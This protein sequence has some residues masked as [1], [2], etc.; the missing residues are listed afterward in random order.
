MRYTSFTRMRE[1]LYGLYPEEAKAA[2]L[3]A[4][5][6]RAV[7]QFPGHMNA[8]GF[9]PVVTCPGA[10]FE[11][12]GCATD[13]YGRNGRS[14][15]RA[16]KAKLAR[17]THVLF[18]LCAR[19]AVRKLTEEFL[20]LMDHAHCQYENRLARAYGLEARQLRRGSLFR[21]NWNGDLA[22]PVQADAIHRATA[23]RPHIQCWVY[24]RSFHLLKRLDPPP[25][26]LSVWLS[27]DPVNAAAVA[28]ALRQYPWARVAEL[29]QKTS[30]QASGDVTCPKLRYRPGCSHPVLP[31]DRAC[32]RCRICASPTDKVSRVVFPVKHYIG[33]RPPESGLVQILERGHLND[34]TG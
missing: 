15:G 16:V 11:E 22:H 33:R 2:H 29:R 14:I 3:E 20:R 34:H 13:C 31:S 7:A 4:S 27:E 24:L 17:N 30:R 21:W 32:V 26:N 19:R 1:A 12:G 28:S 9:L 5:N 25:D 23:T 8:V 10:T 6:D 18:R